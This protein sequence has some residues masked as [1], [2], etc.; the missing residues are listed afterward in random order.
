M[1]INYLLRFRFG[2]LCIKHTCLNFETKSIANKISM[3]IFSSTSLP[4]ASTRWVQSTSSRC[5][6]L[7]R[8][9]LEFKTMDDPWFKPFFGFS[10]VW[11]QVCSVLCRAVPLL[12]DHCTWMT[13]DKLQFR[14]FLGPSSGVSGIEA[15]GRKLEPLGRTMFRKFLPPVIRLRKTSSL[16]RD[17]GGGEGQVEA[18]HGR[19]FQVGQDFVDGRLVAA[20]VRRL[21]RRLPLQ[22]VDGFEDRELRESNDP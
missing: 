9:D 2:W 16:L 21:R 12:R 3:I 8:Q 1:A 14:L 13:F 19:R 4:L 11:K 7:T 6:W 15:S 10:W 20:D 17:V 22:A 5:F 18:R